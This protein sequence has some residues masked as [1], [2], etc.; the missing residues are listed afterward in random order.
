[1]TQVTITF[2]VEDNMYK[3][4]DHIIDGVLNN[5]NEVATNI[6]ISEE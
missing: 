5:L 2:T 1:M 3:D 4:Y 6:E